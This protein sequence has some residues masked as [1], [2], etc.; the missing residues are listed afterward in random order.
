[1]SE[2]K[3]KT[4]QEIA[5]RLM[6]WAKSDG[7]KPKKWAKIPVAAMKEYVTDLKAATD[8]EWNAAA[9]RIKEWEKHSDYICG[10][11]K[12]TLPYLA[13]SENILRKAC[14]GYEK[15][16]GKNDATACDALNGVNALSTLMGEIRKAVGQL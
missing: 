16:L 11:L 12:K 9:E 2:E 10:M 7:K 8:A 15:D 1:M 5:D 13:I 4:P 6:D 14:K 3:K